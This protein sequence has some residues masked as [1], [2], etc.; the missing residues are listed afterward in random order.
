VEY[1]ADI[2][3]ATT[4]NLPIP[5][6]VKPGGHAATSETFVY[7]SAI[8]SVANVV[9]MA[10]SWKT[11]ADSVPVEKVA[12]HV[13]LLDGVRDSLGYTLT[14]DPHAAAQA[15]GF[16]L[17]WT[18]TLL[19]LCTLVGST[20]AAW[21]VYHRKPAGPPP[22]PG[23]RSPAGLGGWLLLVA[24]GVVTRPLALI[25]YFVIHGPNYF[26]Q[27]VW[28]NVTIPGQSQYHPLTA[29]LLAF[30]V[31]GNTMLFV[32]SV[33][34]AVLFFRKRRQFPAVIIFM[35]TAIVVVL[36]IDSAMAYS[37][38]FTDKSLTGL[39]QS[40]IAAGIWIPYFLVSKRVKNTFVR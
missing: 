23:D 39:A 9:T 12:A 4:V 15:R 21:R 6:P 40:A 13:A 34:T 1:P 10:Y 2:K 20:Y 11:L 16:T 28:L 8:S 19:G 18:L 3:V 36:I 25:R 27:R 30:E 38:P 37:I 5:W 31:A 17:N 29:P 7:Q 35:L 26:D 22:L 32:L 33:L 24:L 14:H